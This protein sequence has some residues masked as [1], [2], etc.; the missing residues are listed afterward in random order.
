[1]L[2][3]NVLAAVMRHHTLQALGSRHM[4]QILMKQ[5]STRNVVKCLCTSSGAGKTK[6][7][8][9]IA[10]QL[11]SK[12]PSAKIIDVNDISGGCGS[13][14]DI[15]IETA[16]FKGMSKV[17]QHRKVTEALSEQIKEMHGLRIHT[18]VGES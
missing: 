9:S 18:V 11:K 14:Y 5:L 16:E 17:N 13:M 1:M 7:E 8:Q 12:F 15:I 4:S 6:G 3:W 10:D 2:T